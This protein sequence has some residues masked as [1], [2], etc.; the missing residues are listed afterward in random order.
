MLFILVQVTN[1]LRQQQE[2]LD[3]FKSQMDRLC[4]TVQNLAE[5]RQPTVRTPATVVERF[6]PP[7]ASRDLNDNEVKAEIFACETAEDFVQ[8]SKP[9]T[10]QVLCN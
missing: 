5:Q 4:N 6:L 1:Q 7:T 3:S 8:C 9:A 10:F 2:Q